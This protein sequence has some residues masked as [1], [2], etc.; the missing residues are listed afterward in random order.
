MFSII[1]VS[2]LASC[3]QDYSFFY[4]IFILNH[5]HRFVR[6]CLSGHLLVSGT[7]TDKYSTQFHHLLNL[8][9]ACPTSF[10]ETWHTLH[11]VNDRLTLLQCFL[12]Q[13]DG[14]FRREHIIVENIHA[15]HNIS[16]KLLRSQCAYRISR[17][18]KNTVFTAR[19]RNNISMQGSS[20]FFCYHISVI[21]MICYQ[22]LT[23][24]AS[25]LVITDFTGL[26]CFH[27][28]ARTRY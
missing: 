1:P 8:F 20:F 10:H 5:A 7:S 4:M 28:K 12:C 18:C 27:A 24:L 2:A 9:T 17:I 3:C 26:I 22:C 21:H 23:K 14:C 16:R 11:I 15:I 25:Y 6:I 19:C 13:P